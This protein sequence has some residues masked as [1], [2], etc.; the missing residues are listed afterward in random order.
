MS[1]SKEKAGTAQRLRITLVRSLLGRPEKQGRVARALGLT[2][3]Q[4]SV[5]QYDSPVIDGMIKK[6]PHLLKV[7]VVQ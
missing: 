5:I 6:I 3:S 1:Q 2:K 7:E 4:R